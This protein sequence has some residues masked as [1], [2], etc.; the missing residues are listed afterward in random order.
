MDT[1]NKIQKDYVEGLITEE[2][3][4]N[5]L[6]KEAYDEEQI[7][8]KSDSIKASL[9]AMRDTLYNTSGRPVNVCKRC[10]GRG[11]VQSPFWEDV[12]VTEPCPEC[13]K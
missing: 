10:L 2:E 5:L 9:E 6:Q 1:M 13:S 11:V 8:R 12:R 3:A 4:R 7:W